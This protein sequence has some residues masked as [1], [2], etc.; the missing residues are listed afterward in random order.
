MEV[1][2]VVDI[3]KEL[4]PIVLHNGLEHPLHLVPLV[5]LNSREVMGI[6]RDIKHHH[7]NMLSPT[8]HLGSSKLYHRLPLSNSILAMPLQLPLV[9]ITRHGILGLLRVHRPLS[10]LDKEAMITTASSSNSSSSSSNSSRKASNLRSQQHKEALLPRMPMDTGSSIMV[11]TSSLEHSHRVNRPVAM[12]RPML[13]LPMEARAMQ[14][15]DMVSKDKPLEARAAMTSKGMASSSKP[16]DSSSNSNQP[17][18]SRVAMLIILL[19]VVLLRVRL[20]TRLLQAVLHLQ[21]SDSQQQQVQWWL[22]LA[23]PYPY[24]PSFCL[25]A[26]ITLAHGFHLHRYFVLVC[27]IQLQGSRYAV[28]FCFCLSSTAVPVCLLEIKKSDVP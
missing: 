13:N 6:S 14:G 28:I 21:H 10:S 4:M 1:K 17:T 19:Q 2:Q 16:T 8:V 7:S 22:G 25:D 5:L 23:V 15:M 12:T 3:S 27:F 24:P 18:L 26:F 11:V 9:A 20:S